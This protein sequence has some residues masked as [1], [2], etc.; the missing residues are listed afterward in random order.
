MIFAGKQ[1]TPEL[2]LTAF[3]KWPSIDARSVAVV[4]GQ[5]PDRTRH[6]FLDPLRWH[7][8]C[9]REL[10]FSHFRIG[11]LGSLPLRVVST[12]R[13]LQPKIELYMLPECL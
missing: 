6:V 13:G 4:K 8:P 10:A 7:V 11:Y 12:V 2:R 9:V 5:F 3:G 1:V